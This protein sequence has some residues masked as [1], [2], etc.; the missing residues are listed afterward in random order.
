KK[1]EPIEVDGSS[2]TLE[3]LIA[4]GDGHPM[5]VSEETV[6]RLMRSRAIVDKI[7]ASEVPTYGINTGFGLMSHTNVA[8]E[9][10]KDLQ[11]NLIRS[12]AS[13]VGEP[14]D[15]RIVRRI[16]ALRINTL[17]R[18]R[19]GV[20]LSTFNGMLKM[21]NAGLTPEVPLQG[22]VGASGDLAPLAHVALGLMGEGMMFDP[23]ANKY[24][25]ADEALE[26]HGLLPVI[27]GPKD[28]LS[29]VNGTQFITGVGSFALE[30][31]IRCCQVAQPV[32]ALSVVSVEGHRNAYDHRVAECRPHPGFNVVAGMMRD[33][34]P[35]GSAATT[36]KDVQDAY[37]MRCVPQVHGPVLEMVTQ[38]KASLELEMNSS[39]DNP[40]IFE[41]NICPET[42]N[43]LPQVISAGNFHGEYPAKALDT[44]ALY[45]GE[46]GRIS[47]ARI[48][49]LVDP[50]RNRGLPAF[51][52]QNP[53]LNSGLMCWELTACAL[54]AENRTLS[55]P[56]SAESN[57]TGAGKEDHV[58]MGGFGARKAVQVAENV[59]KILTIEL[60][61][62]THGIHGR[63][64][65]NE[66]FALPPLLEEVFEK[67]GKLNPPLLKDRYLKSEYEKTNRYLK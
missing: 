39:T 5:F 22:T 55:M 57:L 1:N 44:L 45:I 10:L 56:A 54:D 9:Q 64:A 27:L 58:S 53:G 13:G 65:E 32:A 14:L 7:V 47:V 8:L 46:I 60:M 59:E 21:F 38:L 36:T 40:L 4:L 20:S 18:G 24:A 17:A 66:K 31:A 63:R 43:E 6:D 42:G 41:E 35:A 30:A 61:A 26:A 51:L 50:S 2:M 52:T 3:K 15:P 16:L 12:H 48:L 25:P 34:I 19:S 11:A 37:S 62:A 49:L 23:K 67:T 29:L 28:G 33:L